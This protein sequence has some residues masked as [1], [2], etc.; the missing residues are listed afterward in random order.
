MID[1]KNL[2]GLFTAYSYGA[3]LYEAN[4]TDR[5]P[6]WSVVLSSTGYGGIKQSNFYNDTLP[7]MAYLDT[8]TDYI[9]LPPL[10]YMTFASELLG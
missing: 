2:D 10:V 6:L 1:T 7:G 4:Y 8:L 3:D 5:I 9:T